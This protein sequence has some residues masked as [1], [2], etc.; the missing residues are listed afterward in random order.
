L[1]VDA[2]LSLKRHCYVLHC[3]YPD[4]IAPL[5]YETRRAGLAIDPVLGIDA[6]MKHFT[7]L[8]LCLTA[9]ISLAQDCTGENLIIIPEIEAAKS[10]LLAT[11][12]QEFAR[13]L[14]KDIRSLTERADET[15]GPL[16]RA[17]DSPFSACTTV[18]QRFESPGYYQD[19]S[20]YQH[21]D[22]EGELYLLLVGVRIAGN[23]QFT[24]FVYNDIPGDVFD[25]LR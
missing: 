18:L 23:F 10:A 8:A 19:I 6:A 2:D 12:Y 21:D 3:T 24:E 1:G 20:A 7:T 16:Q 22:V 9:N 15:F 5:G 11:D 4:A 17:L 13:L 25:K 14:A